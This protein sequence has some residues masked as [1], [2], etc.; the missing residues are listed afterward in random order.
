MR[1][2]IGR[3]HIGSALAAAAGAAA[4]LGPAAASAWDTAGWMIGLDL[5]SSHADF[6]DRT[7]VSPP[8]AVFIDDDGGGV[9][10][11]AGYGFT[12]SFALRLDLAGA[13]HET[14]DPDVE[15][16]LSSATVEAMVL[17][18]V[19]EA[20]RPYLVG[21]VGGFTARSRRDDFD[22]DVTGPGVT[23]G[24]GFLWFTGRRFALDFALRADFINWETATATVTLPG[25][26]TATVDTPVEEDGAA[27]K[28]LVGVSWWFGKGD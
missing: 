25:G 9:N 6:E 26:S 11:I 10:L 13:G 12:R 1:T 8:N 4:L 2:H 3:T 21:G 23:L 24:A 27:A 17:L 7:T 18:R 16:R 5:A 15:F 22:F 19:P 20:F 28:I 14:T